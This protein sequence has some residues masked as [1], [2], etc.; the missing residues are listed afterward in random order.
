MRIGVAGVSGAEG[1]IGL[2]GRFGGAIWRH[3]RRLLR[4]EGRTES[5]DPRGDAREGPVNR[6]GGL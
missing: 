2:G 6:S 1:I 3:Q 5:G 4:L